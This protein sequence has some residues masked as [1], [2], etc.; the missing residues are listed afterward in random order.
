[1]LLMKWLKI[2]AVS[3][4][5]VISCKAL[6]DD[7]MISSVVDVAAISP[8]DQIMIEVR[9]TSTNEDLTTGLGLNLHYDSSKLFQARISNLLDTDNIGSQ[10]ADD[11]KNSDGSASTDKIFKANW[12]NF[13]GNWPSGVQLPV[14]LFSISFIAS[15]RFTDTTINFSRSSGA[16]G[17]SFV[18]SSIAIELD[19]LYVAEDPVSGLNLTLIKA[20]LDK[21]K[22]SSID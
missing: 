13:A 18:S 1:M 8:G 6:G 17:Y 5:I 2:L 3:T 15:D 4:L 20:F 7:Q 19:P 14:S 11:L 16:A 21:Q 22:N 12:A 9:Y 10:F